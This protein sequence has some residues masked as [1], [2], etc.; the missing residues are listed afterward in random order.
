MTDV[1]IAVRLRR[2]TGVKAS[3]ILAGGKVVGHY[4]FYE[5]ESALFLRFFLC[6]N[7]FSHLME[8]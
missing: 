8:N 4:L 7:I 6:L 1:K 3:A 5:V 2:E